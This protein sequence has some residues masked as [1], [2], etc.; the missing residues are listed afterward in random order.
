MCVVAFLCFGLVRGAEKSE[1]EQFL[2][3]LKVPGNY[4]I[5]VK[6]SA[7]MSTVLISEMKST[8]SFYWPLKRF[9]VP[10][11]V[12]TQDMLRHMAKLQNAPV[13]ITKIK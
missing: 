9:D 1:L 7:S 2:D 10:N 13:V 4:Q 3:S 8:E 6:Q 11:S 12:M 5:T